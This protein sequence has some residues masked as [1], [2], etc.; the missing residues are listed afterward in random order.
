MVYNIDSALTSFSR[1]LVHGQ[2]SIQWDVKYL[3]IQLPAVWDQGKQLPTATGIE[4]TAL[5]GN[6]WATFRMRVHMNLKLTCQAYTEGIHSKTF[7]MQVYSKEM[8]I[9]IPCFQE[10]IVTLGFSTNNLTLY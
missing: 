1:I 9:I 5:N 7:P 8:N 3:S 2:K 10:T 6:L 4:T